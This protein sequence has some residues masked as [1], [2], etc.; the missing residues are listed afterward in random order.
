MSTE[1]EA[2]PPN[3]DM[4]LRDQF[5]QYA[6]GKTI[7]EVMTTP[8]RDISEIA[9]AAGRANMDVVFG[10]EH[11][12]I[13]QTMDQIGKLLDSAPNGHFKGVAL[14]VPPELQESLN[15][16]ALRSLSREEFVEQASAAYEQSTFNSAF[17]MREAG[18]ITDDQYESVIN[19][20]I[21]AF[22]AQSGMM[23]TIYDMAQKALEKGTP[24]YAADVNQE[25]SVGMVLAAHGKI[26]I[27]DFF[28]L[29]REGTDDRSDA[30]WLE[31]QGVNLDSSGPMIVH[32][33]KFHIDGFS[34][35]PDM[36]GKPIETKG[37]DDIL[38]DKGRHV[39]TIA[40]IEKDGP[41]AKFPAMPDP[42]DFT[43][44]VDPDRNAQIDRSA[45]EKDKIEVQNNPAPR[46]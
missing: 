2:K 1:K 15:P 24:V 34:S 40:V 11:T 27:D 26:S 46:F 39:V 45:Y 43:V 10:E 16:S 29:M 28:N 35:L 8:G 41:L 25:R 30:A 14:E 18:T 4:S 20:D 38:Q 3:A 21:K 37:F 5:A 32:R 22:M 7:A 19:T 12:A 44:K 6:Y 42:T 9:A 23:E 36:P 13:Q 31:D 33:G 17:L